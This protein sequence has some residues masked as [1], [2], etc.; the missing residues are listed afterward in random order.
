MR[1]WVS[2]VSARR[3]QTIEVGY[4][5][6]NGTGRTARIEL[7]ASL[8]SDRVLNWARGEIDDPVHDVVAIVRPGV[9]QHERF[10]TLPSRLHPGRYDVAWGLRNASDGA[11]VA[12]VEAPSAL[13]VQ[14]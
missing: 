4:V 12:L 7:G 11:R 14:G 10:F 1:Y 6:N 5:I 8:K 3:G 13:K 2:S 9:T